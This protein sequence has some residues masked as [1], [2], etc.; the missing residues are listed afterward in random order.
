MAESERP[1]DVD[2]IARELAAPKPMRRGSV[3]IRY[4]K[5]NKPTCACAESDGARHGPYVSWVRVVGGKTQSRWVPADRVELLKRQVA[6]GQEFRKTSE[7]YW[8]ACEAWADEEIFG[9]RSPGS[10]EP[11][12]K[13]A[14]RRPSTRA[15]SR[16]SKG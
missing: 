16:R 9:S 5:C 11:V 3:S 15:S 2:A 1:S 13:T 8:Q 14:S 10:A 6:H 4:V 7:A 12:N